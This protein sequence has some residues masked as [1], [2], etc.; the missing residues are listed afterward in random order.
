MVTADPEESSDGPSI[1]AISGLAALFLA[2][3]ML[4]VLIFL[5]LRQRA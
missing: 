2:I 1:L 4:G 3:V 5:L